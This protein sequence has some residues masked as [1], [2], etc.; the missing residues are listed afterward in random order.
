[1]K[2]PSVG[3]RTKILSGALI[4]LVPLGVSLFFL[5]DYGTAQ[6]NVAVAEQKGIQATV[7]LFN[8][9]LD[10]QTLGVDG[11]PDDKISK[12]LDAYSKALTPLA[13]DLAYNA[14][15]MKAAGY[16]WVGLEALSALVKAGPGG[17]FD[18]F[19]A[20][21]QGLTSDLRYLADSSGIVLDPDLDSYYLLL[22]LYQS[23][24]GTL[25]GLTALRQF[26]RPGTTVLSQA[27]RLSLYAQANLIQSFGTSLNDQVA[28][29]V[30]GLV[31]AYG[32]VPGYEAAMKTDL[33]P[34]SGAVTSVRDFSN[35][36]AVAT[37]FNP[38]T[39][40]TYLDLLIPPLQ[41]FREH[42]VSAAQVMLDERI[43][44]FN[45]RLT[46]AFAVALAGLVLGL[47]VLGFVVVSVRRR[48]AQLIESLGAVAQGD[49]TREV[50]A[51][52]LNSGDELGELARSVKRLR[53]D[54]R[55]QVE[56]LAAVTDQLS[57]LGSTLSANTEESAA[58]IE[59]M[60]ATSAQVARFAVSQLE[61]TTLAGEEIGSML[62]RITESNT[63]TQGMATQFFL[64][65][66]SM[67]A[68]RRRIATTANEA[69]VTGDLSEGLNKT[70]E[71]GEASLESL[72]Q[73]IGGVVKKTQEI[74]EIVQ[75]ILD[76][77]DR[78]N[79]L[80]MNAAIEAAHAGQS[81]RGFAVV[82]DEIRK[83]AETSSK[84]AQSI[85]NLVDGIAEAAAQ[86]LAR[87]EATGQSFKTVRHDIIAVRNASQ[88]IA[89]QMLQQEAE[90]AKLSEGLQDFTRFYGELSGS[91]EVQ[92]DQSQTV[93]R[94]IGSLGD[95]SNQISQSMQ[96]Q[97][98]GMEQ[99]TEA[100]IQ[101]RDTTVQL[102]RILDDLTQLMARF[103]V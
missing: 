29:S 95:A 62:S 45:S 38:T 14:E 74:Q 2:I 92:V 49:L 59:E 47:A 101:V 75:F 94:A 103:T 96:E 12:D 55:T 72:R 56:S 24:P 32:P 4:L 18:K 10:W 44:A 52:L 86:T 40:N 8:L 25:D 13:G 71:Q 53:G 17:D 15:A 82:A 11:V 50:P 90:D 51:R 16:S 19:L 78:T 39:M 73:A 91:M 87:S 30:K 58:A 46:T 79:L 93:Q 61:Q 23:V 88:S 69:R 35:Q 21:H 41:Q 64:F 83:L 54:L 7:P 102:G 57:L 70:G 27:A 5:Y 60:T 6:I 48:T 63:L 36:T 97:K 76:I 98:I 81:G 28:R 3:L 67:E 31:G 84:Q 85:K 26:S 22:A 33:A 80:S 9:L 37:V 100:V 65:S 43:A 34:L 77:S 1:M 99:S 89:G 66:Q 20:V 68:N 42:A